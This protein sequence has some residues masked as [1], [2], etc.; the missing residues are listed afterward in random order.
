MPRRAVAVVVLL[1]VLAGCRSPVGDGL[2]AESRPLSPEAP[3]LIQLGA[4]EVLS[5][6][7]LRSGREW[8]GGVSGLSYDGHTVTAINDVGHWLSFRMEVDA[9][10]RP[11]SFGDLKIASLGGLDGSKEDGDAEE[12]RA[13]RDGWVVSFERR[14]RLLRYGQDLSGPPEPLALPPGY[15]QQPENGGV[16]AMTEL[17]DGRLLLLSEEG[18]DSDG[19][20]LGWIGRPGAWQVLSYR[21]TGQ[22]HPSSA[23]V[24]PGGD[25][26]VLERRFSLLGGFAV[27]LVQVAAADLRPGKVIEGRELFTLEPPYLVDNY[28]GIAVWPRRDGRLV[29]YL[30]ADDNFSPLQATLL[31]SILLPE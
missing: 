29:A 21:R 10:G 5:I 24:L 13:T 22:F 11:V 27:R 16:E 8:F 23:T 3:Q 7:Q 31:M 2:T 9:S 18:N 20:G 30:V 17:P 1:A 26:L 12:V 28:E 19:Q 25:V 4:V 6:H 15:D 14:H